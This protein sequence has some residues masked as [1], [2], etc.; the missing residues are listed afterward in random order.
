[1]TVS[2]RILDHPNLPRSFVATVAALCL[3]SARRGASYV[4][5]D[6]A[7]GMVVRDDGAAYNV[8]SQWWIHR[9]GTGGENEIDSGSGWP[10]AL[11]AGLRFASVVEVASW[12]ALNEAELA[13]E[14]TLDRSTAHPRLHWTRALI[15][16]APDARPARGVAVTWRTLDVR[17]MPPEPCAEL[18]AQL[19]DHLGDTVAALVRLRDPAARDVRSLD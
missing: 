16:T 6:F 14:L 5:I 8:R 9:V 18:K 13:D 12:P 4:E 10:L 2:F 3:E 11:Y 17:A 1:M 19:R 7:Q 15:P